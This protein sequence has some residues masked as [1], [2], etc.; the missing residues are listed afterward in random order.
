MPIGKVGITTLYST[1]E[2]CKLIGRS[3]S[4]VLRW[5]KEGLE[6]DVGRDDKHNRIWTDGDIKRFQA[7]AKKITE[8]KITNIRRG[9]Q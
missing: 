6:P 7:R 5:I 2:A 4:A 3:K 9:V 1:A 8:E